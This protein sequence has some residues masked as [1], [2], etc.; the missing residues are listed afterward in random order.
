MQAVAAQVK[1]SKQAV[2][3]AVVRVDKTMAQQILVAAVAA[4]VVQGLTVLVVLA[5]Q[6]L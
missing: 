3:A 1:H 2:T 5:V 4:Q 6:E